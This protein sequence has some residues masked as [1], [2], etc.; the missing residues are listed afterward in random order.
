MTYIA[1]IEEV[2][3]TIKRPPIPKCIWQKEKKE[4][5]LLVHPF[6][7]FRNCKQ[8]NLHAI[9]SLLVGFSSFFH[10]GTLNKEKISWNQLQSFVLKLISINPIISEILFISI[11]SL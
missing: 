4:N 1:N 11:F 5:I 6:L 8:I 7:T 10:I 9:V 3:F 2:V